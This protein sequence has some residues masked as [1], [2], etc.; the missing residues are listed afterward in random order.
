[1]T[2][3]D[4]F[5]LDAN[6]FIESAKKHYAFDI[7]PKFWES[8]IRHSESGRVQSIDRVKKEIDKEKD[9]LAEW[10]ENKF[11]HA[12]LSSDD[13]TVAVN[14][15]R[16]MNWVQRQSQFRDEAK[17]EFADEKVADGWLIAYAMAKGLVLVTL[18]QLNPHIKRK[19]PIPN[20]CQ[21]FG[22]KYITP[23]E[24]LRKLGIRFE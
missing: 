2:A 4:K 8:L 11:K 21:A 7:A 24:M 17:T 9:Q 13:E 14:F 15:G 23:F 5:L 6:V 12:F 19:V 10:A 22:V 20:V 16:L 3:E 18:E 1:M